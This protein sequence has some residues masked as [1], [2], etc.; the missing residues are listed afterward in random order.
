MKYLLTM[1]NREE[2][3]LLSDKEMDSFKDAPPAGA[4]PPML[5]Y[6]T[7]SSFSSFF[8]LLLWYMQLCLVTRRSVLGYALTSSSVGMVLAFLQCKCSTI[9]V[10][11]YFLQPYLQFFFTKITLQYSVCMASQ[12]KAENTTTC[13]TCVHCTGTCV[14]V[15]AFVCNQ[16]VTP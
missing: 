8:D 10:L 5:T 13:S 15:C 7:S 14:C 3:V 6:T 11:L 12:C 2:I 9:M 16:R 1:D 4:C